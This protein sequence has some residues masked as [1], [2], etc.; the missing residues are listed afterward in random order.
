MNNVVRKIVGRL[1]TGIFVSLLLLSAYINGG[2]ACL[3]VF[4]GII[5]IVAIGSVG[6]FLLMRVM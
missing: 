6:L 5:F 3:L 4:I 1:L 2:M